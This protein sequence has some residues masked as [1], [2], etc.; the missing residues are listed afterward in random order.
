MM[1]EA[2]RGVRMKKLKGTNHQRREEVDRRAV[3]HTGVL[4]I[5]AALVAADVLIVAEGVAQGQWAMVMT[6]T[7]ARTIMEMRTSLSI[8]VEVE[9]ISL[10]TIDHVVTHQWV[11][12]LS[13]AMFSIFIACLNAGICLVVV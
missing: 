13:G 5:T 11:F 4:V 2:R 12:I 10:A 1:W 8:H 9:D 3:V 7:I 6:M